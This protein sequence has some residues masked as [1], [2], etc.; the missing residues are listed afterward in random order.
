M[1]TCPK[2]GAELRH[3]VDHDYYCPECIDF[4]P[5]GWEEQHAERIKRAVTSSAPPMMS[6]GTA[7]DRPT[8]DWPTCPKKASL[9][10]TINGVTRNYCVTHYKEQDEGRNRSS[11]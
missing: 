5:P 3:L 2:C 7:D 11:K 6:M 9:I 10:S 4:M 8:C 1:I